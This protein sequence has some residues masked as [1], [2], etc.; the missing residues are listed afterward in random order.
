VETLPPQSLWIQYSVIGVFILMLIVAAGAFWRLWRELLTWLELQDK[1]REIEREKQRDWEAAQSK[2][3]DERWQE[4]FRELVAGWQMQTGQNT[5][6]LE[7]L[8]ERLEALAI[9]FTNHD[10]WVRASSITPTRKKG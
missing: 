5:R 9:A 8:G 10:T 3:R 2:L 6:A 1:K 7:E 4:T